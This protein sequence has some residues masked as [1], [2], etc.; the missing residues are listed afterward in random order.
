[1]DL[2]GRF[3][4]NLILTYPNSFVGTLSQVFPCWIDRKIDGPW[5][6]KRALTLAQQDNNNLKILKVF[7][8]IDIAPPCVR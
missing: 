3:A 4:K 6:P 1:M 8:H 5:P 2:G 7:I